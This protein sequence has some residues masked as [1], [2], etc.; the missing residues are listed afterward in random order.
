MQAEG[1]L[2]AAGGGP[3][4]ERLGVPAERGQ[5]VLHCIAE[6]KPSRPAGDA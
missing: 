4:P 3:V 5:T 6:G 2:G 1:V